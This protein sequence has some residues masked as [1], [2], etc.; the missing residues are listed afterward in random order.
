M[1]EMNRRDFLVAT[2]VAAA[3]VLSL[4]V[5]QNTAQAAPAPTMPDKPV[6]C[7]D[8]KDFDKDG[9]T[10]KFAKK[11][12]Y[13]FIVRKDGKLYACLSLCTH[14]YA[15]LTVKSDEFYCPKHKS[16]FTY[17]GTVTAGPAKTSLPRY[18][19]SKDDKGHVIVDCSKE[20]SESKWDDAAS[21]IK[22]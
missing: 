2:G 18:A 5:L 11:P 15:P 7:G 17:E 12:N 4:P 22:V 9:V 10:D 6:D 13:F 16:E 20:F 8:L 21:F 19:I 14:K 1:S 3:A